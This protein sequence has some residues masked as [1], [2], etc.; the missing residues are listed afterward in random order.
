MN[1]PVTLALVFVGGAGGLVIRWLVGVGVGERHR[2]SGAE[3]GR[4]F[5]ACGVGSLAR[6]P[7]HALSHRGSRR[8]RGVLRKKQEDSCA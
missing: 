6:W 4:R 3:H 8:E 5:S 7:S 2:L 1:D